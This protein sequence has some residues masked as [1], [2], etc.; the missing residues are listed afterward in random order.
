MGGNQPAKRSSCKNQL[1]SARNNC[2][3]TLQLRAML[4]KAKE[5]S[6]SQTFLPPKTPRPF[7]GVTN[8][9]A[10]PE[11]RRNSRSDGRLA[12]ELSENLR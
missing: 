8:K 1:K 2:F 3:E 9:P 4:K 5:V 6:A 10:R 12:L 7:S 11:I